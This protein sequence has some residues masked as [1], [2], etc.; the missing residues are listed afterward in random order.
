MALQN[1]L[2]PVTQ[3]TEESLPPAPSAGVTPTDIHRVGQ[4]LDS[5][6]SANTRANYRSAWNN[7]ERWTQDRAALATVRLHRAALAA[8]HKANGHLDPTD[9][10]GGGR[11]LGSIA[12]AHG[13][14]GKQAKPLTAEA[15]RPSGPQHRVGASGRREEARIG[16]AGFLVGP[17]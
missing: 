9:N 5:S 10:E 3:V 15:L 7:F 4:F 12:R 6:V 13:R 16:G 11:V 17:G 14:A 2:M 8:D 1:P